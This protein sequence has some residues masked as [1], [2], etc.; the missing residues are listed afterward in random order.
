MRADGAGLVAH[1]HRRG[2]VALVD[3]VQPGQQGYHRDGRQQGGQGEVAQ[4]GR[5]GRG[6][7]LPVADDHHGHRV[8]WADAVV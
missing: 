7:G 2:F 5:V 8:A 4:R 1:L 3:A 6:Q